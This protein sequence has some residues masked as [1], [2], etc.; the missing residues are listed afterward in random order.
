[1]SRGSIGSGSSRRALGPGVSQRVNIIER[2]GGGGRSG[3]S[4]AMRST[5][6]TTA[7]DVVKNVPKNK[8]FLKSLTK[9]QKFGVGLAAGVVAGLAYQNQRKDVNQRFR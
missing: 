2:G 1:M 8:G 3:S 7:S 6:A 5:N 9:G 4:V